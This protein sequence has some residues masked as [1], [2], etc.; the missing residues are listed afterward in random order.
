MSVRGELCFRISKVLMKPPAARVG[1]AAKYAE[2]RYEEMVRSWAHLSNAT[3][4]GKDVLDF[5]CGDGRI[6][7]A[8]TTR[9]CS[10]TGMDLPPEAVASAPVSRR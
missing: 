2:W 4:D 9:P 7:P 1:E 5:G 10:I 3:V 6:Y 8:R